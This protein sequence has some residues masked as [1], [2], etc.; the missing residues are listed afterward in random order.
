MKPLKLNAEGKGNGVK[1]MVSIIVDKW[2][3]NWGI[4]TPTLIIN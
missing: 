2:G 1:H 4:D 3:G